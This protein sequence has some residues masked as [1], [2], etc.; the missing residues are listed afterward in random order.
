MLGKSI[1][2][3]PVN[4]DPG[5]VKAVKPRHEEK[6][7]AIRRKR[8]TLEH[9]KA[10]SQNDTHSSHL[11]D[12]YATKP[13]KHSTVPIIYSVA[14]NCLSPRFQPIGSLQLT[15]V[16]DVDYENDYQDKQSAKGI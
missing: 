2:R 16:D 14:E 4:H 5:R 1:G 12:K 15:Q 3:Q 8:P 7:I 9:R 10:F 11:G 6:R 13:E